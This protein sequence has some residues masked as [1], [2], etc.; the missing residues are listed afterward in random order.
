MVILVINKIISQ[1]K[2]PLKII[3]V[4]LQLFVLTSDTS[5]ELNAKFSIVVPTCN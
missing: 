5:F 3:S 2:L 1:G 4:N